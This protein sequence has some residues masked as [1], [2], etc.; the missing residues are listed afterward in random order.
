MYASAKLT[1]GNRNQEPVMVFDSSTNANRLTRST[2]NYRVLM[3]L[4]LLLGLLEAACASPGTPRARGPVEHATG[5][6]VIQQLLP[7]PTSISVIPTATPVGLG[8][9]TNVPLANGTEPT[10]TPMVQVTRPQLTEQDREKLGPVGA[11]NPPAAQSPFVPGPGFVPPTPEA[12]ATGTPL[13]SRGFPADDPNRFPPP[14]PPAPPPPSEFA[15]FPQ[16]QEGRPAAQPTSGPPY[17]V[18]VSGW[19]DPPPATLVKY[20]SL[21]VRGMVT[22][23]DPT[24]WT[25]PDGRKPAGFSRPPAFGPY[26]IYKPVRVHVQTIYSGSTDEQEVVLYVPGGSYDEG[27]FT[28]SDQMFHYQ[29]GDEVIVFLSHRGLY[30]GEKKMW[31]IEG[32]YKIVGS[33]ARQNEAERPLDQVVA[34]ITAEVAR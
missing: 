34:E 1:S 31:S 10:N 18:G 9:P 27:S 8:G 15:P 22:R 13:I 7:S 26:S 17:H 23:I 19:G 29:A 25:T 5:S 3:S 12:T 33:V 24:R 14:V 20:S 16:A 32:K 6:E 2:I 28:V 11:A 21:I 4:L 30:L